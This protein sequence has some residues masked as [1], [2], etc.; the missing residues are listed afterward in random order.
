[1]LLLVLVAPLVAAGQGRRS[2]RQAPET[3][4]YDSHFVFTRIRYGA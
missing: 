1:M 4:D 3:V 2:F